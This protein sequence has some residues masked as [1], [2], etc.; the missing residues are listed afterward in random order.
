MKRNRNLITVIDLGSTKTVV[1]AAEVTGTGLRYRGAGVA[2][3]RGLR[4]G[5]IVDLNGA[6]RTVQ[7]TVEVAER[8]SGCSLES[9]VVGI[10]GSHIRAVN[11]QG[12][13]NLGP[14]AREVTQE[15]ADQAVLIARSIAL[16]DDREV[17][18]Y[19]PQEYILDGQAGILHPVGMVGR[20]L[21]VRVHVVTAS[22]AA[23]QNVISVL[24]K[25]GMQVDDTVY[26][27]LAASDAALRSDEREAGAA[28]VDIGGGCTSLVVLHE[29]VARHTAV[30]PV[31][32]EHF[33]NDLA[34][35][36]VTPTAAAESIKRQS[37]HA[38]LSDI[39]E[40]NE[41]EVP[42]VG[43]HPS[44]M[45]PQRKVAE[46]LEARAREL[47]E[48]VRD[49]LKQA[50]VYK[51]LSGGVVLTGGG[52]RLGGLTELAEEV[53]RRPCRLGLPNAMA[54][55]PAEFQEPEFSTAI[56]MVFYAQRA[57]VLRGAQAHGL[58]ARLRTLFARKTGN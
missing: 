28:L 23:T 6:A 44:R 55:L 16:P 11:S 45:E 38:R 22:Q 46:I 5:V 48:M 37:G 41:V 17:L 19:L 4:K 58:C 9:A 25:A 43:E 32:G 31:G 40:T 2:E 21:E 13:F 52:A 27:A 33:T 51:L 57:R 53:L 26:E 35:G 54:K 15:D 47:M 14:R 7:Q 56:G 12:G 10:S 49:N 3:S 29:G 1:L 20:Q 39:P 34:T 8:S 30:L 50:G 24:N 42:T 36:L 18:H